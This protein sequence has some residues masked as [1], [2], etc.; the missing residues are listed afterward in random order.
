MIDAES[1]REGCQDENITVY[2]VEAPD[3]FKKQINKAAV[4][5]MD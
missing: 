2:S 3:K 5:G 4:N 1:G